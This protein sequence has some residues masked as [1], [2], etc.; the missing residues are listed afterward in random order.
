[1]NKNKAADPVDYCRSACVSCEVCDVAIV[2]KTI[3]RRVFVLMNWRLLASLSKSVEH[4]VYLFY[5]NFVIVFYFVLNLCSLLLQKELK[6]WI[7][8]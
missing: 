6:D 1:M 7:L 5:L 2:V 8:R 4:L 3:M